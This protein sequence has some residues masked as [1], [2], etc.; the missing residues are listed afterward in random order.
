MRRVVA[1]TQEVRRAKEGCRTWLLAPRGRELGW[2]SPVN[3][4]APDGVTITFSRAWIADA[5]H[6]PNK[7]A[8]T[9]C[10][11][12]IEEIIPRFG[13]LIQLL[14][15]KG[16]EFDNRLMKALS[17]VYVIDKIRASAYR[18]STNGTTEH[19][20]MTLNYMLGKVIS[21]SQRDWDT[22]VPSVMAAYR[23][24]VHEATGYSPNFLIFGRELRAPIDL[25][26][27]GPE[28]IEYTSPEEFV[29]AVC[30]AQRE[31]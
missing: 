18:P 31:T 30:L 27:G 10:R 26:L 19:L 28:D 1:T 12:L 23:A 17:D 7:E 4:R 8:V 14:T 2:I 3:T 6:I 22:K 9:I 20:H 16:R 29:E 25:V 13:V 21:E 11:V 15:D 24:T 5:Y